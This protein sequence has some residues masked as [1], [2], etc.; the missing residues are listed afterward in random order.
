MILDWMRSSPGR[1]VQSS[2]IKTEESASP[3]KLCDSIYDRAHAAQAVLI[4]A[5]KCVELV[6][7]QTPETPSAMV[8]NRALRAVEL[9]LEDVMERSLQLFQRTKKPEPDRQ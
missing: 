7:E 9:L 1:G 4:M 6:E 5:E 3:N 8:I 2:P